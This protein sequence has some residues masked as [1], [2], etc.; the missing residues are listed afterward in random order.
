MLP[1]GRVVTNISM[2]SNDDLVMAEG[3]GYSFTGIGAVVNAAIVGAV[4]DAYDAGYA[5]G[6][7]DGYADGYRDGFRDGVASVQ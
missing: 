7:S 6:Y 5:D 4:N 2:I 1:D 3:V